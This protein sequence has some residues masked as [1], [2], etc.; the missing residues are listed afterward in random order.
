M[1]VHR[2]RR[3]LPALEDLGYAAAAASISGGPAME[4]ADL[5][6]SVTIR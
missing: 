6:F 2:T 1:R 5:I 3:R 4:I